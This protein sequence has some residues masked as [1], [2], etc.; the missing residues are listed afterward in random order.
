MLWYGVEPLVAADGARAVRLAERSKI[1]TVR[2]FIARRAVSADVARGLAELVPALGRTDDPAVR[3]DLLAGIQAALRGRK[4]VAMPDGWPEVAAGLMTSR[5]D[6]V[7][8]RATALSLLFGD[9]KAFDALRSVML[10]PSAKTDRRAR[11]LDDLVEARTPNLAPALR[12]LLGDDAL[13]APALRAL[14]AYDDPETPRAILDRYARYSAEERDD[15]LNTLA[16]RRDYAASLLDAIEKGTVPSRDLGVTTARQ[17]Q[18]LGDAKLS[19]RLESAWGTIRPT[20]KEKAALMAR[21]KALLTPDRLKE[22][23]P[24]RGRLVFNRTC[25]QCHKLYDAGG[26]VGPNLTGSDRANLD[27]VLENVLD[28]GAAVGREYTLTTVATADGRVIAGLLREQTPAGI[29][30]QTANERLIVPKED[31]EEIKPST[32]SMMPEGLF[33]KLS[34]DEVR[35]LV[36][37]LASKSQ[38]SI[39]PTEGGGR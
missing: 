30:L 19:A 33:E 15:A 36:A 28:P 22:A 35:D 9:S 16:S 7:R 13:R 26:D 5:D 29:V 14:A 31:V 8:E 17:V 21:Y 2:E 37:Y 32:A 34:D 6:E 18:A 4:R 25:L 38:V 23:D 24:S 27:Y 1:P 20:S 12:R 39:P 10:D 11:A 3:R